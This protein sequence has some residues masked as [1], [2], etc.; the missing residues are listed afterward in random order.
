MR[1]LASCPFVHLQMSMAGAR[2]G[3]GQTQMRNVSAMR[4]VASLKGYC[5]PWRLPSFIGIDWKRSRGPPAE[6]HASGPEAQGLQPI[7][8]ND[9]VGGLSLPGPPRILS[10]REISRRIRSWRPAESE[11]EVP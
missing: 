11:S 4:S 5:G 10:N 8:H 1:V 7:A 9:M 6:R 2:V 3:V